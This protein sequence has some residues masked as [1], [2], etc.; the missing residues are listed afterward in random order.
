MLQ[1]PDTR[2]DDV[3]VMVD[4]WHKDSYPF[5]AI[6]MLSHPGAAQG[7]E[8]AIQRGDGTI[9]PIAFPAAGSCVVLQA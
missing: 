1:V 9:L 3:D 4:D 5:V 2:G 6:V 7:G 8:T